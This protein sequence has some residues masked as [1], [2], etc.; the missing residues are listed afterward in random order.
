MKKLAI[1]VTIIFVL[2]SSTAMASEFFDKLAES[3]EGAANSL[4]DAA[5]SLEDKVNSFED[6]LNGGSNSS[7]SALKTLDPN[8]ETVTVTLLSGKQAKIR[9]SVKIFLDHYIDLYAKTLRSDELST[10][11]ALKVSQDYIQLM[12]EME[13]IE[14]DFTDDEALYYAE[15]QLKVIQ[16][17][18]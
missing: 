17:A 12:E 10:L 16:E 9:K 8:E 6:F 2:F 18:Q 13:T 14:G 1:I 3:L 15:I 5:N 4:E 7:S 11:E